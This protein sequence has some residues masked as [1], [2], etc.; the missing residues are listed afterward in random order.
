MNYFELTS[1][2]NSIFPNELQEKYYYA[3][4][5]LEPYIRE[6]ILGRYYKKIRNSYMKNKGFKIIV[7]DSGYSKLCNK[8]VNS[9][10]NNVLLLASIFRF[11]G[12]VSSLKEADFNLIGLGSSNNFISFIKNKVPFLWVDNI[13]Y[14]QH[15]EK[16]IENVLDLLDKNIGS[17][18]KD[19]SKDFHSIL[20]D[21]HSRLER[22]IYKLSEIIRKCEIKFII[23]AVDNAYED[24]LSV[25]AA[26]NSNVPTYVIVHGYPHGGPE[27]NSMVGIL[28]INCDKLFLWND[29]MR[30]LFKNTVFF[31]K[32]ESLNFYPKFSQS[33]VKSYI[34]DNYKRE[35]KESKIIT[36]F[37]QPFFDNDSQIKRIRLL[38]ELKRLSELKG[39]TF[40]IRYHGF[41][42]GERSEEK[43]YLEENGIEVSGNTFFRDLFES[44]VI[45][46]INTTVLYEAYLIGKKNVYQIEWP[47]VSFYYDEI[48]KIKIEEIQKLN[49]EI[50][51]TFEINIDK[52]VNPEKVKKFFGDYI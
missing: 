42:R 8:E 43:K 16:I 3:F 18:S 38:K 46:G 27:K 44:D 12:F 20:S 47:N 22:M 6:K 52:F 25:L 23:S 34:K 2:L 17:K 10:S 48:K 45:F 29:K 15:I 11:N 1:K 49:F 5:V 31:N 51:N 14:N 32:T 13:F 37:S 26:K 40:R 35:N 36:F 30:E 41:E 39:F 4:K 19:F 28:P 21:F 33:Y 7:K 24:I 50:N 9:K